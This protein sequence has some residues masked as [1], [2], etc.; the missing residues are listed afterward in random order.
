MSAQSDTER[1]YRI[2]RRYWI[3]I[4]WLLLIASIAIVLGWWRQSLSS[5]AGLGLAL[6]AFTG[7][8]AANLLLAAVLTV[9][10]PGAHSPLSR[11]MRGWR[12]ALLAGV[13]VIDHL[14]VLVLVRLTGGFQSELYLLYGLLALKPAVYS[15]QLRELFLI[16]YSSGP[17]WV[18]ASYLCA[19]S[20]FFLLDTAFVVR[21]TILFLFVIGCTIIGS[22]MERRQRSISR[23]DESLSEQGEALERQATNAQRFATDL[24]NRLAELRSLEESVKA[25]NSSLALDGLLQL[26]AENA[27]QVLRGARCSIGLVDQQRDCVVTAAAAGVPKSDLWGTAF[28]TGQGVAGWVVAHRQPVRI[29]NIHTDARY[30]HVGTWPVES[31]LSVPLVSDGQVIG[32]LSAAHPEREAFSDGDVD[33]LDAFG[34]QAVTAVKNARLYEQLRQQEQETERLYQSVL[35]KSNELEAILRGIGDGVIVGDPQLRLLMMNPVAAKMLRITR[36]PQ[37]GVRLHELIS[38]ESLLVLARDTLAQ[39]GSPMVREIVLDDDSE[40]PEIYQAVASSVSG[41][42]GEVRG[43]VVV[44]RDITSQKEIERMKSDFLSVVSHELKTPLTTIK[45]YVDIILMGKTGPINDRQHDFLSTVQQSTSNLQRLINDLLEFSRMEAGQIKLRPDQISVFGV[46]AKVVEQ[47]TPLAEEGGLVLS[48]SIDEDIAL[49][50]ADPM[51]IEQVLTNLVSNALKFTPAQGRVTISATDLGDE[52][53]VSVSDTGIGIS[54]QEQS[55]V[56]RRF[57]Q[58]DSGATRS[59][60]GAG[61]GLTICKFIVEYHHGRIW[62]ESKVGV[63]ST[64]H[65]VLPK[66]LPKDEDLVIDFTIPAARRR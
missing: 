37:A 66:R 12:R 49:V 40:R 18:L 51:R 57:Y 50:E 29:G 25:I 13:Y 22:V 34:D 28:S 31:M 7:Y 5:R 24:A 4:R 27:T 41:A 64:F 26:I 6:Y 58:V 17:L 19:G 3:P 63:G 54:E 39:P 10:R 16:T 62:V 1:A 32:T 23:L 45:G 11:Q 35:E 42:Q 52:V 30:L 8:A 9:G 44:L 53:R 47:L 48:N 15:P 55:R 56:F 21:Y 43:V 14:Y 33:L 38:Q 46:A 65:F 61:L 36:V 20:L 2:E 59:Y 60:R